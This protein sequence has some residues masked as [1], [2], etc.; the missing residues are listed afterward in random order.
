MNR[1]KRADWMLVLATSFWGVSNGLMA[2]CLKELQP[3]TLNAFRFSTAFIVLGVAQRKHVFRASRE[4]IR[5]SLMIGG[6]LVMIYLGATFGILYTSVSNVGFIGALT[7]LFTPILEF[8]IYRRR[9]GKKLAF[10][11][12]LCFAGMA[13]LTLSETM[14]P[15][16]GDI[17]CL[18][19]PTFY[20]IDLMLT[21]HAVSKPEVDPIA[22]GVW[23]E[24][25]VAVVMLI[26]SFLLETPHLPASPK[27]WA[28]GLFLGVFCSGICFVI[29]NIEQQYTTASH[30]SLIFTLEPVFSAIFAFFLLGERLRVRGYIGAVMMLLSLFVMEVDVTG[31]LKGK[32]S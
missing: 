23:E 12:V 14:R 22:L 32:D 27:V 11:L 18:A 3:L 30:A 5:Y 28:S 10:C 17:I 15:A 31:L 21:G 2:I 4:T 24:C 19:S 6:C 13:L 29:Q 7:V 26:L 20:A 9:P 16:L 25:V 8:L 1:Q